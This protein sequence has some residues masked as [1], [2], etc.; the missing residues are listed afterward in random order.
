MGTYYFKFQRTIIDK[1]FR[2]SYNSMLTKVCEN[3]GLT[4]DKFEHLEKTKLS[5]TNN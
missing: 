4:T 5:K 2:G 1:T 3:G